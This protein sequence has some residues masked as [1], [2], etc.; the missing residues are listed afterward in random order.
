[1]DLCHLKHSELAEHL[2]QSKGRE[3]LHG[4]NIENDMGFEADSS[5]RGASA[6]RATAATISDARSGVPGMDGEGNYAVSVYIQLRETVAPLVLELTETECPQVWR[7]SMFVSVCV[8]DFQMVGGKERLAPKWR[9]LTTH[10]ELG[11]RTPLLDKVCWGCT[12][13]A[14][15]GASK[16]VSNVSQ[17][18]EHLKSPRV[19]PNKS[20]TQLKKVATPRIDDPQV[21]PEGYDLL[22]CVCADCLEF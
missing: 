15:S 13:R 7:S 1:M 10:I 9:T 16:R 5:K 3:G 17:P 20:V 8:D 22:F 11:D 18:V 4:D 19:G 6:S 2:Q 12:Q 21:N 14:A